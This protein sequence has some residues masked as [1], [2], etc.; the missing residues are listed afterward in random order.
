M[1]WL[2]PAWP[3]IPFDLDQVFRCEGAGP[4]PVSG[5][6]H[7]GGT[8]SNRSF[9]RFGN[10]ANAKNRLLGL[11][12]QFQVPLGVF[13]K[14]AGNAGGHVGAD[15]GQLTPGRITIGAL[16]AVIGG[17]RVPAVSNAKEI[18]RHGLNRCEMRAPSPTSFTKMLGMGCEKA[19]QINSGKV[20]AGAAAVK[21]NVF[22][23]LSRR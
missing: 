10:D 16:G 3:R 22:G 21:G 20:R 13:R 23:G 11:I 7:S 9:E 6:S 12:Q 17:A 4:L 2:Y 5:G 19:S 14:L 15:G 18:E 1:P 8:G